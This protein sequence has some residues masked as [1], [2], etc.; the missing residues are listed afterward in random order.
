VVRFQLLSL[1]DVEPLSDADERR[2]NVVF[3]TQFVCNPCADVWHLHGLR[4]FIT[5]VPVVL[6]TGVQ[7]MSHVRRSIG[8][9][10]GAFIHHG[11][12]F[13]QALREIQ[14][15]NSSWG[16][17]K[18]LRT[19]LL[20]SPFSYGV[21]FLWS[22]VS[23]WAIPPAIHSKMTVSAVESI[24][25]FSLPQPPSINELGIEADM[26]ASDPDAQRIFKNG[27]VV[28]RG[29]SVSSLEGLAGH[30]IN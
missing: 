5:G 7:D 16:L 2:N 20:S 24:W 12:D 23:V 3:W 14:P 21:Y 29:E 18:M 27:R 1:A 13:L 26:V 28:T 10:H 8:S 22:N 30:L 4:R 9:N 19:L 15:V 11:P 25:V 17:W 6:V